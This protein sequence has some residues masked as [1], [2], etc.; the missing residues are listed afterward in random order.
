MKNSIKYTV[1]T[2][3]ALMVALTILTAGVGYLAL[4]E[5]VEG[6]N[7]YSSLARHTAAAYDIGS[8]MLLL[9]GAFSSYLHYR[10]TQSAWDIDYR[11][12][13]IRRMAQRANSSSSLQE[14]KNILGRVDDIMERFSTNFEELR[15]LDNRRDQVILD[16]PVDEK[17]L[18]RID[19]KRKALH[20]FFR[21]AN[22]KVSNNVE[23]A[24]ETIKI[25]QESIDAKIQSS[26]QTTML[27]VA[28]TVVSA[29]IIAGILALLFVRLITKPVGILEQIVRRS[30]SIAFRFRIGPRGWPVEFVSENVNQ[31]GYSADDFLS[32]K[33][34][35]LDVVHPEDKESVME[36]FRN[37]AESELDPGG[38]SQEY[39]VITE[40]GNTR[41][42]DERMWIIRN[43]KG[44]VTHFEGIVVDITSRKLAEEK[45]QQERARKA[46]VL[47]T[48][49]SY[50]SDE[51][52]SEILESP[53]G[54]KLGGELRDITILVS[55]L[56]GFTRITESM[57]SGDL[58]FL[59]NR[60]LERMTDIILHYSG[61]IDEFTG[62]GILVFFGAPR[63]FT[64]H[65][66]RA[67][68][69]AIEM[70]SVMDEFNRE[71]IALGLPELKM[72]IGINSGEL[73]VG[74]IGSKKRKKYGAVGSPINVAFRVQAMAKGGE[75]LITESTY[76]TLEEHV[77]IGQERTAELKGINESV[78][79]Y[80]VV[81]IRG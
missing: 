17:E 46:F 12:A 80:K 70:Q 63:S 45:L 11:L 77:I 75:T 23:S 40:S 48:F 2:G 29:V 25:R 60:Y 27:V 32:G 67:S 79:I 47:E 74:N 16:K 5:V 33:I 28:I 68:L 52:V 71:S 18:Q 3:F 31:L 59:L 81:G 10:D 62:D 69:C 57:N 4:V 55:D 39:R 8:N 38:F 22:I 43:D 9:D 34:N 36:K 65:A 73:V 50:L 20:N 78:K 15:N 61:T 13:L 1:I 66:K 37:E 44:S 14:I 64:D 56:R 19:K 26:F 42:I 76:K 51:V 72:G 30:P 21:I 7:H 53:E 24:R 49:G 41:W 6:A 35:L 54:I 58:L